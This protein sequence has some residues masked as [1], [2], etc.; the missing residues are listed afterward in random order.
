MS[1]VKK[2]NTFKILGTGS[3]LKAV[4]TVQTIAVSGASLKVTQTD[5]TNYELALPKAEP[6]NVQSV[7][8]LN[9]SGTQTVATVATLN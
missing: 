1:C 7:T 6:A 5:G 4:P 2:C 9:A 3:P 8:V